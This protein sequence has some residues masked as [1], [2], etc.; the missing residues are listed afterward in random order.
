MH[1]SAILLHLAGA[2]MLLLFA[3]HMVRSGMENAYGGVLRSMLGAA[4]QG[5]GRAAAGGTAAAILLQS[6]TAVAMLACGFAANG[7]LAAPTG[8]ALLLGADLGSALVVRVLS[9]DLGWLVPVCLFAGGVLHLK[10]SGRRTR[11]I[12]RMVLGIGF[13]L[14]SLRLIG[15]ATAPLRDGAMLP[16]FSGYLAEDYVTAFL[17]G[18]LF[19]WLIHSSVAAILMVATF[20]GQGLVSLEAAVPLVLGANLGG[21][22]IAFWLSRGM[23]HAAQRIPIGNLFFRATASLVA[24]AL[25]ETT[26]PP[27]A[28]LGSGPADALVNFHVLFNVALVLAGLPFVAMMT[29]LI[30]RLLPDAETKATSDDPLQNR[31]TA[32]DRSVIATPRLALASATRELLRM[33]EL[34][35]VMV[36]PVMDLLRAGERLEITRVR[37]I[38]NAVNQAHTDIKLYLAEVNRG[39]MTTEEASRS[40]ELTDFAINLEHAGD[41]IAKNLLVLAEERAEKNWRFSS[42]GWAELIDLHAQVVENM[43][44]SL[45]VLISQDPPSARQLV[46]EKEKMREM[47][48]Y[49]HDRHLRRL[50]SG[51]PE[52]I[53]TSGMHI[54]I[55][56]GLKEI[57]SLLVTVAYPILTRSGDLLTS[58][59]ASS[60][61]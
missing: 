43:H 11:E 7:I 1:L 10:F 24:L 23:P 39:T 40:I 30:G 52:S 14:L 29:R 19:T 53:E 59:L 27:I 35:E 55:A 46:L 22:L 26:A 6:S 41:I 60:S 36:R 25:V 18:A 50:Q 15:T 16:S 61:P 13:V 5:H 34:V 32:L 45:N 47:A 3:V 51:T 33:G 48:R 57:N 12:G 2:T 4:R 31:V 28:A 37:D 21:G 8:L 38:D 49:T 9:F 44:L 54:E 58:R 20:A 17:V 42:E 56:R